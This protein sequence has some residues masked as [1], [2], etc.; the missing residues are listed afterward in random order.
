MKRRH[1]MQSI[2]LGSVTA[3]AAACAPKPSG[4]PPVAADL[5]RIQWRAIASWPKALDTI[6]GGL[7]S[8][9]DRV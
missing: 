7:V 4:G 9:C 2:G 5:P 8:I 1:L 3:T 6:F